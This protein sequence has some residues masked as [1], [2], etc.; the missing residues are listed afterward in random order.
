MCGGKGV[1]GGNSSFLRYPLSG[2]QNAKARRA[3]RLIPNET[4]KSGGETED[5]RDRRDRK[6]RD[7]R[8]GRGGGG[9]VRSAGQECCC[10]EWSAGHQWSAG[11]DR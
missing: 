3:Y 5:R 4:K 1:W 10:H 8:K 11:H 9:L 2:E 6:R 7:K